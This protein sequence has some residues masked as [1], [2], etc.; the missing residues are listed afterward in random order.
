VLI[1]FAVMS[2]V[3]TWLV[4]QSPALDYRIVALGAVLPV[5]EVPLGAGP[6]HSLAAP[7][8]V[9]GLVM[10]ATRGRRLARRQWL[11]LPIG[12]Y[13]HLVLDLAWTRSDVFWWPFLGAGIEWGE[14]FELERGPWTVLMELVGV[15]VGVWA[16]RRFGLDDEQRRRRFL[17]TGQLDRELMGEGRGG[18]S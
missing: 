6:L 3:L 10:L 1:W 8:L 12:M 4:F 11:G 14:A 17:R 13:L 16:Y 9:L 2:I 15:V 7:T 18:R 5:I